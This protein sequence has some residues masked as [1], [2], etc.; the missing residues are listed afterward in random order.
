MAKKRGV[1]ICSF[2]LCKKK[3]YNRDTR[4]WKGVFRAL[5]QNR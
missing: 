3:I 1:I 2:F 5:Q 4:M